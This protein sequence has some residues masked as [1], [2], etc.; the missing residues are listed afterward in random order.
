MT[1]YFN[2]QERDSSPIVD[3]TLRAD[4]DFT[5]EKEVHEQPKSQIAEEN[6]FKLDL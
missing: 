3:S 5:G 1:S 6:D 2:I 4:P